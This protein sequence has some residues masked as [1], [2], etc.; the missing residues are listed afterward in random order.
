MNSILTTAVEGITPRGLPGNNWFGDVKE[1]TQMT[2]FEG[3]SKAVNVTCGVPLHVDL[4]RE[5][6]SPI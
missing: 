1:W 4:R 5:D 3:P 2:V 6:G